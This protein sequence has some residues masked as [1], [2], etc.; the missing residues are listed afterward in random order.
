M[1]AIND[2]DIKLA[3]ILAHTLKGNAGQLGKKSL[4]KA[5]E[6]IESRLVNE[7]NLVSSEQMENL[8]SELNAVIAEFET[9]IAKFKTQLPAVPSAPLMSE[10]TREL[11]EKLEPLL[12]AGN[13]E[14]LEFIDSLRLIPGSDELVMYMEKYDFDSA[15]K[16][17]E[18]LSKS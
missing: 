6:E 15:I 1:K 3:H 10:K 12:K 17:L 8:K 18:S 2:G 7:K 4:Q 11:L 16:V 13:P 5:A 9:E 14:C